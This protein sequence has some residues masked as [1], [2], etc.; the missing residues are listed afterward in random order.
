[1]AGGA[2][3]RCSRGGAISENGKLTFCGGRSVPQATTVYGDRSR[4]QGNLTFTPRPRNRPSPA[5]NSWSGARDV[6]FDPAFAPYAT[7][8]LPAGHSVEINSDW[9]WQPTSG[10]STHEMTSPAATSVPGPMTLSR[11]CPCRSARACSASTDRSTTAID[12]A[13]LPHCRTE[14]LTSAPVLTSAGSSAVLSRVLR[15]TAVAPST[16]AAGPT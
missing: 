11:T 7:L 10:P 4:S 13:R 3:A 15:T 6:W 16:A 9:W 8:P 1:M 14:S 5:R 12:V 2:P